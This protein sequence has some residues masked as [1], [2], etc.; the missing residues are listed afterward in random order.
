MC[1]ERSERMRAKRRADEAHGP[2]SRSRVLG[3]VWEANFNDITASAHLRKRTL[4]TRYED[5][6]SQ[7]DLSRPNS[8]SFSVLCKILNP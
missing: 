8:I 2:R 6:F 7:S 3:D 4:C 1:P 5:N